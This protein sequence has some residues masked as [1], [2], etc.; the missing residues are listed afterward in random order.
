MGK[1]HRDKGRRGQ[2][3]CR[4]LLE[5]RDFS[6]HE[7]NAGTSVAD[8]LA[9]DDMGRTFSVEVKNTVS[10]NVR[11]F[12]SQAISQAGKLPYLIACKLDGTSSWLILRKGMLPTV[13][14]EKQTKE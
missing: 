9:I 10:I 12:R 14:H 11:A 13:W 5:D 7:L 4:R 1:S 3:A 6:V 2:R 8:F